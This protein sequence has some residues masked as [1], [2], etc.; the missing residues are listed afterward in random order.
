M[1]LEGILNWITGVLWG[2]PMMV[3][4]LAAGLYFTIGSKFFQIRKFGLIF[5][6][7]LGK[8]G[9]SH[10]EEG[11][12][13]PF[14][15]TAAGIG[16]VVGAGNIAGVAVAITFGGPGA[17][18]WMWITA[19]LG[20]VVKVVEVS[21]GIHYRT[22][23]GDT[24][25]GGPMHFISKGLGPKWE[26]LS[27]LYS[28]CLF[29]GVLMTSTLVQPHTM[30]VAMKTMFNI[31]PLI[32][33]SF[34]VIVT[35]ITIIGGFSVI[36]RVSEK[37][38]PIM[39][40]VYIVG[41]L[42]VIGMNAKNIPSSFGLIFS[43]A[44]SPTPAMGGFAGAAVAYT[45]RQGIARGLFSNEAGLGT[46]ALIHSTARTDHPVR[47]GLW[48]AFEAFFDTII[49]CSITALVI[50]STGMWTSGLTG[51]ELT[52]ASFESALGIIGRYVVGFGILTFVIS[53]MISYYVCFETA[54]TKLFGTK[55]IF[56]MKFV[57]LAPALIFATR[58]TPVIWLFTDIFV[59][60]L[61][62]PNLIGL[63]LLS[64]VFFK[65]LLPDFLENYK[66]GNFRYPA[67]IDKS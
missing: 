47:Q 19:I 39:G 58:P 51:A 3:F 44:L 50:L 13:T 8:I 35:G 1:T 46:A 49:I 20:M 24:V 16:A 56:P 59:G 26:W 33:V 4:I 25:Y 5:K 67:G 65:K 18:F 11:S 40:L 34:G 30:G 10:G 66:S 55:L 22:K 43:H 48:G 38:T 9:F 52:M 17:I 23:I 6:E 31:H 45:L 36:G 41:A 7:T 37:L 60:I 27:I 63:L 12:M 62:V 14:Q 21:I 61:A 64:P 28:I 54:V 53:T 2:P 32:T 42:I 15:A 29:L 57:F